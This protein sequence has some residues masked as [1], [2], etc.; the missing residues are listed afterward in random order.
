DSWPRD[1]GDLLGRREEVRIL[2]DRRP[3]GAD[4]ILRPRFT[5]LFPLPRP[6]EPPEQ[7]AVAGGELPLTQPARG[8]LHGL[9]EQP[10][11]RLLESFAGFASRGH[12]SLLPKR[13]LFHRTG[14]V[15][16]VRIAARM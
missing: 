8:F 6:L 12:R 5:A 13:G 3:P 16:S 7:A 15:H 11:L 14:I 1:H 9:A 4:Q 10:L 2:E